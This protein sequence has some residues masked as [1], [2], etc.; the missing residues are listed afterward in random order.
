MNTPNLP[1]GATME[2]LI[3]LYEADKKKKAAKKAKDQTPEGKKHNLERARRYY[4]E[5]KAMVLRKRKERYAAESELLKKRNL[6]YYHVRRAA[7]AEAKSVPE[8]VP[9]PAPEP[10]TINHTI[11][12]A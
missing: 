1:E 8:T 4:A 6:G 11:S 7:I 10:P 9:V 2:Q 5:N 12:W 3:R